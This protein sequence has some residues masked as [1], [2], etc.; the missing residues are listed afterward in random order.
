MINH[1]DGEFFEDFSD[2]WISAR[3]G[4][5]YK[6]PVRLKSSSPIHLPLVMKMTSQQPDL[7]VNKL[8]VTGNAITV[9]IKN[10][11]GGPVVDSFWVDV[12]LDPNQTPPQINQRWSE[13][14][15]QGLVWGVTQ[16][17][18][19]NGELTLTIGD[20]YYSETYSG[21]GGTIPPGTPVW[22]QVDSVNLNTTYGAVLESNESNNVKGP[23]QPRN[24]AGGIIPSFGSEVQPA[25]NGKLPSR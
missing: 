19:I 1:S 6:L 12:Y 7:I 15:S 8:I 16:S 2:T 3:L 21:F 14:A 18:P 25:P 20:A 4:E 17:I 24:T 13:I 23:E 10:I 9:T 5:S 22:A 11:G